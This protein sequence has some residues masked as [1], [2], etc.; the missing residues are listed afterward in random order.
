MIIKS[1]LHTNI[2][3]LASYLT[4][5]GEN[6][7]VRTVD[8]SDFDADDIFSAF[9]NMWAISCNSK[10]EKAIHHISINPYQDEHITDDAVFQIIARCETKYGYLPNDHQRVVIEHFKKGRRH[11]H[12]A[13]NRVSLMTGRA[14]HPGEHWKKSK[15][16]AREMERE[17][18][19]QTPIPRR[20]T[21]ALHLSAN[22]K[23]KRNFPS[24]YQSLVLFANGAPK[25]NSI[26]KEK[27]DQTLAYQ[28]SS[29]CAV[30][31]SVPKTL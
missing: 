3:S 22:Y 23:R 25:L 18:G 1:H 17:L 20:R 4:S 28:T 5:K 15:Q 7:T 26:P 27:I 31:P 16:A 2:R 14:V 19:L 21:R 10:V 6:E 13:W 12:V 8:I 9:N 24:R 11:Y 29:K 30:G